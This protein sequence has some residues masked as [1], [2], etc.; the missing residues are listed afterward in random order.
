ME[1]PDKFLN[2]FNVVISDLNDTPLYDA[3]TNVKTETLQLLMVF[4]T[5]YDVQF[6]KINDISLGAFQEGKFQF[7]AKDFN[8]FYT[9]INQYLQSIEYRSNTSKL[10]EK[11]KSVE[12]ATVF[13]ILTNL[14][15]NLQSDKLKEINERSEKLLRNALLLHEK[16]DTVKRAKLISE[17]LDSLSSTYS[18]ILVTTADPDSLF[19]TQRKQ[20]KS[21]GLCNITDCC[22]NFFLKL[23]EQC[24]QL[25]TYENLLENRSEMYVF[26]D[27][28]L[29]EC[30]DHKKCFLNLLTEIFCEE[31]GTMETEL[32]CSNY[33][34]SR[35]GKIQKKCDF[36]DEL[37]K[38]ALI[39]DV[40]P[41]PQVLQSKSATSEI[42]TTI[43]PQ[44]NELPATELPASFDINEEPEAVSPQPGPSTATCS[45]TLQPETDIGNPGPLSES[46]SEI[47]ISVTKKT[48]KGKKG[49][50]IELF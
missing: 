47:I 30:T 5:W 21:E 15:F 6:D 45:A 36:I 18:D 43:D 41:F 39:C 42:V 32:D 17:L 27:K 34:D 9:D 22:Y 40:I 35:F 3:A 10:A 13:Q 29:L 1:M 8:K 49:G 20:N 24:R 19:E 44:N 12:K 38:K 14:V 25:L 4:P 28:T 50:L 33:C 48:P 37:S 26:V 2:A 23:E 11:Y 16:E 46:D 31:H 7:S